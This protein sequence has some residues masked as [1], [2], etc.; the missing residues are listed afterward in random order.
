[1]ATETPDPWDQA[2]EPQEPQFHEGSGI[3]ASAGGAEDQNPT[4][5][6]IAGLKEMVY[7]IDG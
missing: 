4:S 2:Q 1:M 6:F 3:L 7:L 5:G